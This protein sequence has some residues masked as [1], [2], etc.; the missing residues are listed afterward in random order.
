[1][2]R[3]IVPAHA[4]W[5]RM[6]AGD[7][8]Q[9]L[10]LMLVPDDHPHR[11]HGGVLPNLR[12]PDGVAGIDAG[13]TLTKI[14]RGT[15]DGVLLEA[16][17]TDS[18][19]AVAAVA[20]RVGITGA[21]LGRVQE[22]TDAVRVQEIDA[23]A[24]GVIALLES[25]GRSGGGEFVLALLGTGT[26]F[27]AVRAGAVQHLGGTPMGGGSFAGIAR[28]VD[29]S[30]AYEAMIAGAERGDRRRV[31]TMI[32]DVYPEGIGRVGPD[33]TAAHLSRAAEG[34]LDDFLAGLLNLHGENIAQ[35]GASRAVIAK[36]PR[37]VLAGGFAHHNP[38]LVASIT[39][40]A[41]LFGIAVETA[42]AP[43][44]AGAVGAALVAAESH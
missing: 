16:H 35:I 37:M 42:P 4:Q 8:A 25:D 40:M 10:E 22:R 41:R 34:S 19:P 31:D 11:L 33:L 30:L 36:I 44:F 5:V 13:M 20:A 24:R 17:E 28:R 6:A 23:A 3:R 7:A 38:A 2:I 39:S 29:P 21:L 26:A 12:I 18:T 43:G 1:L 27:A 15:G 32:S 14:A 9:R